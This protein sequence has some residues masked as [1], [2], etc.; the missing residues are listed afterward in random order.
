MRALIYI[1]GIGGGILLV[2]RLLGVF[3]EFPFNDLLLTAAIISLGLICLP[4]VIIQRY[5][6]NKKI[7]E[8]IHSHKYKNKKTI[9]PV[10]NKDGSFPKGWDMNTTPFRER[11]SGLTWGGGNLYGA[12]AKRGNRRSL[13]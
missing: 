13:F 11:K 5:R 2:F 1:S 12:K 3:M 4:L 6:Q 10:K 9:S 8:I 7:D